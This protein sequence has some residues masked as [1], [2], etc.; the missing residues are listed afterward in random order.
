MTR[1]A[2]HVARGRDDR[3]QSFTKA[4]FVEGGTIGPVPEFQVE[5]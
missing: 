5:I 2:D 1:W 4:E 3:R